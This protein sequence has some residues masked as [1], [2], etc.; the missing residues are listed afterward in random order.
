MRFLSFFWVW[1]LSVC[2]SQLFGFKNPSLNDRVTT[3]YEK[4]KFAII[5]KSKL[6]N[7]FV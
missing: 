5:F 6:E 2:I 4:K 3:V 7:I 1:L